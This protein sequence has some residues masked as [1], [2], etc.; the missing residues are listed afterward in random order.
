MTWSFDRLDAAVN[1]DHGT[2]SDPYYK[3]GTLI[4]SHGK[5]CKQNELKKVFFIVQK[6]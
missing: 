2:C 1:V 3:M 5:R 6:L 4:I